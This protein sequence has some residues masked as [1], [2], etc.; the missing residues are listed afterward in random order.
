MWSHASAIFASIVTILVS[1]LSNF[2]VFQS[3]W[4]IITLKLTFKVDFFS[5]LLQNLQVLRQYLRILHLQ[6]T[7]SFKYWP[8]THEYYHTTYDYCHNT[9]KYWAGEYTLSH[10]PKWITQIRMNLTFCFFIPIKHTILLFNRSGLINQ[11]IF[12]WSWTKE[13]KNEPI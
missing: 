6:V 8:N 11:A 7:T 10:S 13:V 4:E 9:C 12:N 5:K 2:D 1:L 3:L